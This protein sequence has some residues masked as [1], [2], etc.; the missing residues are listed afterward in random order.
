M[1]SYRCNKIKTN[2]RTCIISIKI[3]KTPKSCQETAKD[4]KLGCVIF[5]EDD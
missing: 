1:K 3:S 5:F 2:M 4:H